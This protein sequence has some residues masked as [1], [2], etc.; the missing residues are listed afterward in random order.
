MICTRFTV[1][2][3]SPKSRSLNFIF[4]NVFFLNTICLNT[5]Y[6]PECYDPGR[7][8]PE[9]LFYF[10]KEMIEVTKKIEEMRLQVNQS[11]NDAFLHCPCCTGQQSQYVIPCR[12]LH[13]RQTYPPT[14]SL[15]CTIALTIF[16][17][18]L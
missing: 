17:V 4:L 12:V 1:N 13:L 15:F 8:N 3:Y 18:L 5:K 6:F 2:R 11:G 14:N 10:I 9:L 16:V 7:Q